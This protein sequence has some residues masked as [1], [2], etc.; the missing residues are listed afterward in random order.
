MKIRGETSPHS[1][2]L[3]QLLYKTCKF[4]LRVSEMHVNLFKA[5]ISLWSA[6]S[7]TS[8]FLKAPGT[9]SS[10]C[11]HQVR[12]RSH[13]PVSVRGQEP[14]FRG[15]CPTN[16]RGFPL[17]KANCPTQMVTPM[18]MRVQEERCVMDGAVK[19]SYLQTSYS[20]LQFLLKDQLVFISRTCMEWVVCLV[21]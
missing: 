19:F 7:P 13:L 5:N 4:F 21:I 11:N 16:M 2:S 17:D 1:L 6:L 9:F 10:K 18:T 8:V 3:E 12:Q 20:Q 15:P 14:D